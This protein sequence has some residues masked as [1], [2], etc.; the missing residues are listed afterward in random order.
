VSLKSLDHLDPWNRLIRSPVTQIEEE[1]KTLL[2]Q[3]FH[4]YDAFLL[5][6]ESGDMP[7]RLGKKRPRI[8]GPVII[9]KRNR[10]EILSGQ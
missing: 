10:V 7:V 4:L 6:H 8:A 9:W 2:D 3:F 5:A 1:I